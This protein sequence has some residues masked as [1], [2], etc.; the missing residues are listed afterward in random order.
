MVN[1]VEQE[2]QSDEDAIVRQIARYNVS[3]HLG[4][5]GLILTHQGERGNDASRILLA[6]IRRGQKEKSRQ[7]AG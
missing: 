5:V 3:M 1:A 4:G 6:S 2:V 7:H